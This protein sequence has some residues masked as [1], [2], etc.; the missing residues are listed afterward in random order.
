MRLMSPKQANDDLKAQKDRAILEAYES[1]KKAGEII[2]QLNEVK[3]MAEAERN[4]VTEEMGVTLSALS[5]KRTEL[6]NEVGVLERKRV[7]ALKPI[8]KELNEVKDAR[9]A[10]QCEIETIKKATETIETAEQSLRNEKDVLSNREK[11]INSRESVL[12]GAETK[13]AN[14][15][16]RIMPV[17]DKR[18]ENVEKKM[19]EIAEREKNTDAREFYFADIQRKA[20]A[21]LNA[22]EEMRKDLSKREKKLAHKE[23]MLANAFKEAK[24]KK[25]I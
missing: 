20:R 14:D 4:R 6:Q 15:K 16:K 13:F 12:I 7:N 3:R 9:N 5:E 24:S 25:I 23:Q 22:C 17:L 8:E 1:A 21:E 10:L 19:Q 18:E 11:D 2:S